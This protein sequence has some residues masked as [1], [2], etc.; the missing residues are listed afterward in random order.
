M[1]FAFSHCSALDRWKFSLDLHKSISTGRCLAGL[2]QPWSV[3]PS[4]GMAR[5]ELPLG[6]AFV[7]VVVSS[8]SA[9]R[10][11]EDGV[12][13]SSERQSCLLNVTIAFDEWSLV[14]KSKAFFRTAMFRTLHSSAFLFACH[15]VQ[16]S[17]QVSTPD[18]Q[19]TDIK[20]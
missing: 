10:Q 19:A 7:V 3:Q 14:K 16:T 9:G 2:E 12:H 4:E 11:R 18:R 8:S 5:V 15:D 20:K 13:S 1:L 6:L 17:D